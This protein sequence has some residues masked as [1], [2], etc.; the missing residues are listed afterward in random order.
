MLMA[1]LDLALLHHILQ[2]YGGDNISYARIAR[3]HWSVF[4]ERV[5]P[6]SMPLCYVHSH[7]DRPDRHLG[8][9]CR[10]DTAQHGS[11]MGNGVLRPYL[12]NQ[13]LYYS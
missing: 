11:S 13:S 10:T 9:P 1:S 2:E 8:T 7:M 12:R 6:L 4:C 5:V 3:K